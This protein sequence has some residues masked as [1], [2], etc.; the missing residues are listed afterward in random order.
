MIGDEQVV[1]LLPEHE[2]TGFPDGFRWGVGTSS[3]QVEGAMDAD[4]KGESVWDRFC[5]MP[6]HVANGD[7]GDTA[8]DHYRR[9]ESDLDLLVDLGVTGYRFSIAWPRVLPEGTGRVN[10]RGLDFYRRLVDGLL[11]R[12]IRPLATV[13]HWDLPQVLQD[14]GGWLNRDLAHIF[15]DYTAVCADALGDRVEAWL[16]HNEPWV[17]AHVGHFLGIKPPGIRD[18][19]GSLQV[20][21]HVLYSHGLAVDVLR[22]RVRGQV[23]IA[24]NAH[25]THPATPGDPADEEAARRWDGYQNRWYLD[26]LFHGR[27]PQDMVEFMERKVGPLSFV[28]EGDLQTAARPIDFL[29]LNFYHRAVVRS[30]PSVQP[31]EL[32]SAPAH[33]VTANRKEVTPAALF[34]M[35]VRLS[36]D[37]PGIPVMVTENGVAFEDPEPA[38]GVVE[39]PRRVEYF[40]TH[41][42]EVKRA[43][44][45]GVDVRGYYAWTL[46]D[47]FEWEKGYDIR[48]GIYWVDFETQQRVPK[49]SALWYRDF[50]ARNGA[51]ELLEA[52]GARR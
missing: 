37:Y 17:S 43:I 3:Y 36:Q 44:D 26:A 15:A 7:T 45:A 21:H 10:Q 38:A 40:R 9:W 2:G 33:I 48:F 14:R 4:G 16:T 32:E 34:E 6:G 39:D 25:A 29:G 30:N 24:L 12:G 11:E 19:R 31:L 28:R 5:R 8:C 23:G 49:R 20:G 52:D 35:L 42:R 27:Y 13:Y 22:D 46:L 47:N 51:A 41:L 1:E 18:L 50:I